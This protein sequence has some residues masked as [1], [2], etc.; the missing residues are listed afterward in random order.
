M[1][2]KDPN[3][4]LTRWRM[5]LAEYDFNVHYKTGKANTNADTL[6]IIQTIYHNK[7]VTNQNINDPEP[8]TSHDNFHLTPID[9]RTLLDMPITPDN[10]SQE[11]QPELP[12]ITVKIPQVDDSIDRQLKQLHIRK[13]AGNICRVDDRSKGKTVI[14]DV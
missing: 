3:S 7:N 10:I 12:G 8:N 2:I 14:K 9:I 5:K 4:K 13:T 11:S 6:S 1:S